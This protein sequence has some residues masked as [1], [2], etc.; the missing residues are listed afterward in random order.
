MGL[1][2]ALRESPEDAVWPGGV[3]A[4]EV[5]RREWILCVI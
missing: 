2:R 5:E 4:E 1:G 3:L